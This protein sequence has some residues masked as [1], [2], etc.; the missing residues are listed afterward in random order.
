M[1]IGRL[2]MWCFVAGGVG[3]E[4]DEEENDEKAKYDVA[5]Q[6]DGRTDDVVSCSCIRNDMLNVSVKR[7]TVNERSDGRAWNSGALSA[8]GHSV[9]RVL[10]WFRKYFGN[11]VVKYMLMT[12]IK[13]FVRIA[14]FQQIPFCFHTCSEFTT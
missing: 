7:W 3:A 14:I 2:M 6:E 4:D 9:Q 11:S 10:F 13:G 12:M 1:L 5:E 8:A